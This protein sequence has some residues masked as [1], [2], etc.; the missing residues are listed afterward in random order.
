MIVV[1]A[2]S[3]ILGNVDGNAILK[4]IELAGRVCYK[5]EKK[6]TDT[7]AIE[8]VR[9]LIKRGHTAVLEHQSVS[10]RLIIDR[11]VSHEVMRHRIAAYC[12]ESTRYCNYGKEDNITVIGMA[13]HFK[14][15]QSFDVWVT[16]MQACETAYMQLLKNGETPQIARSVLPN[17]LKTEIICTFNMREWRHF[18]KLRTAMAAHP[19]MREITI[20]LL[21]KF[22]KL[23]PVIFEDIGE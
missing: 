1:D 10:V 7:S 11:G 23:I 3:K 6:I 5:S 21:K 15:E 20:P 19:Q 18:F 14:N 9:G 2:K 22:K 13:H 4:A 17:S 16:A 8:F 12:Q